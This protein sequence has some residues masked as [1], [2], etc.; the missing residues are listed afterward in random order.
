MVSWS[1]VRTHLSP[2]MMSLA[3]LTWSSRWVSAIFLQVPFV[4]SSAFL[5]C[6]DEL[7]FVEFV[8]IDTNNTNLEVSTYILNQQAPRESGV[9]VFSFIY[10]QNSSMENADLWIH[11]VVFLF[12]LYQGFVPPPQRNSSRVHMLG[13]SFCQS[14]FT[15]F[16][17]SLRDISSHHFFGNNAGENQ[18]CFLCHT[19]LFA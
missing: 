3:T 15:A 8:S 17:V 10:Y 6:L 11:V 5:Y 1:S 13:F 12:F 7:V 19:V 14:W 2:Q 4:E 9:N 16:K 18:S